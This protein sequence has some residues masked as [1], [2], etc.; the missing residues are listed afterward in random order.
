MHPNS[1]TPPKERDIKK[2]SKDSFLFPIK[3]SYKILIQGLEFAVFNF[4]KKVWSKKETMEYLKLLG[5]GT[6]IST[7]AIN[8]AIS[9]T[10][11]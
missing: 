5:V 6:R 4:Y 3:L 11:E 10:N 2:A 9:K 7:Y 1:P 8:Y